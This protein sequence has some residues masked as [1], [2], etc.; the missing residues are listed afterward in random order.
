MCSLI[1]EMKCTKRRTDRHDLPFR[2]SFYAV[3]V[4]LRIKTT[5]NTWGHSFNIRPDDP[6]L[7]DNLI[8]G[9]S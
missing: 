1:S 6:P 3:C 2:L 7:C 8:K 9:K 5:V 4:K